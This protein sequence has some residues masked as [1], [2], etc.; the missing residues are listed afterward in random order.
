MEEIFNMKRIKRMPDEE[1]GAIG[2]G[3]LIVFIGLILVAAIASAV[4]VGVMGDLQERAKRTG[5]ETEENVVPPIKL[6]FAEAHT[7]DGTHTNNMRLYVSAMEG[8]DGYDLDNLLLVVQGEQ[9]GTGEGFTQRFVLDDTGVDEDI[10]GTFNIKRY[11]RSEDD[12]VTKSFLYRNE[13]VALEIGEEID[14]IEPNTDLSMR[15]MPAEGATATTFESLTPSD[16]PD[17]GWFELP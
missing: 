12:V 8:S 7:D 17:S 14:D 13:I 15:F 5:R 16:Y 6:Q 11:T 2:I 9:L 1:S 3:T 4:I 10:D